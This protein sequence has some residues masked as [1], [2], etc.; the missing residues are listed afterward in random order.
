MLTLFFFFVSPKNNLPGGG[1]G[2]RERKGEMQ[3]GTRELC[4]TL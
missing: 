3:E 4:F 2:L 1:G